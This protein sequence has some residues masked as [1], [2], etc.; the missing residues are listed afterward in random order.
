MQIDSD[1][2]YQLQQIDNNMVIYLFEVTTTN[3]FFFK[4]NINQCIIYF[5]IGKYDI[6]MLKRCYNSYKTTF[7]TK[8]KLYWILHNNV[9]NKLKELLVYI[10]SC[11]DHAGFKILRDDELFSTYFCELAK[12]FLLT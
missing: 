9:K 12:S 7:G 3:R 6:N 5:D 11:G 10:D 2:L 1:M 4:S 8:I